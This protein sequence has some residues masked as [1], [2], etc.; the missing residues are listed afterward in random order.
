MLNEQLLEEQNADLS[1]RLAEVPGP[2]TGEPN[3]EEFKHAGLDCLLQ[4]NWVGN[5]CDYA[6]VKPGHKW[7]GKA[8][9]D[10]GGT[11]DYTNSPDGIIEVHGGLTYSAAC[12][13]K[14]CHKTEEED[15]VWWFGFD[16]GHAFDISPLM[17]ITS[18]VGGCQ[19]RDIGYAREQTK[20]L[21]EQ[22]AVIQ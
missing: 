17:P 11:E 18:M 16:C 6:A 5:W 9:N 8:Y 10:D 21:A 3:R 14:I 15:K 13:G 1:R 12:H 22:L 2:W 19:Y 7:Y 20:R 4:R